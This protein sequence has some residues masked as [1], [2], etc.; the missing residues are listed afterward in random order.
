MNIHKPHT[1]AL[2]P[3]FSALSTYFFSSLLQLA[4]SPP[5]TFSFIFFFLE[6]EKLGRG[7]AGPEFRQKLR[8][9]PL[10]YLPS[11]GLII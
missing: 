8:L 6:E 2:S 1:H 10:T 9:F 4:T 5:Q 7:K 11:L 3:S